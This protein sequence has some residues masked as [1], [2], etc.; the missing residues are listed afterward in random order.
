MFSVFQNA[1]NELVDLCRPHSWKEL[2]ASPS[3][4]MKSVRDILVHLVDAEAGW[5]GHAVEGEPREPLTP[6]RF[7]DL[8]GILAV[9]EPRRTATVRLVQ[10]LT[11]EEQ[12]S[13]RPSPWDAGVFATVAEIV[14]HVVTHEQ[15]HRGQIFTRLGLLGRRDLPDLDVIRGS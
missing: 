5:I 14:W 13:R 8:D 10:S 3:P 6:D 2:T 11:P 9:W 15:Y 1:P 7:G 12:A 4:G